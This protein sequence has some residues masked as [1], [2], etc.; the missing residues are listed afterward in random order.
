[1]KYIYCVPCVPV[2][3]HVTFSWAAEDIGFGEFCFFWERKGWYEDG[4]QCYRLKCD[5]ECM[6]K[7]FIKEMLCKM[8]DE[9]VLV[10]ES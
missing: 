10:H 8:V 9:S 1:M 3:E 6:S 2:G 5:N 7:E 4:E